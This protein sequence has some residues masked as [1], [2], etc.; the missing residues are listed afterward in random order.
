MPKM[1]L[2]SSRRLAH[3]RGRRGVAGTSFRPCLVAAGI[4]LSMSAMAANAD[5]SVAEAEDRSG[6]SKVTELDGLKVT[7]RRVVENKSG[8][9]LGNRSELDT[10][11]SV[12]TVTGEDIEERQASTLAAVFAKD[13]SVSDA[14]SE[15]SGFPSSAQIRGLASD[16]YNS[17]KLNG[18]PAG[19]L[20]GINL[21]T[22]FME[23]VQLLK[24]S[25]GFMYGFSA[26]GGIINYVTKKPTE[27]RLASFDAGYKSGNIYGQHL[28]LG[29]RLFGEERFGYRFNVSN[30]KGTAANG[31]RIDRQ[32][33]ALSLEAKLAP[34]LTWTID[35]MAQQ[36]DIDRPQ[37]E[38]Y[39][40]T[41]YTSTTLP[42]ALDGSE[43]L[44]TDES[45]VHNKFYY[46]GTSLNW[47]ISPDWSLR[48]DLSK[49]YSRLLAYSEFTYLLN[50]AGDL[51]YSTWTGLD[52]STTQFGQAMLQGT[53][54]TGPITHELVLGVSHE[55]D[56]MDL[57]QINFTQSSRVTTYSN[58][59]SP[60][61]VVWS[62]DTDQTTYFYTST[63]QTAAFLSDTMTLAE[64]WSLLA[65]L[66]YTRYERTAYS[67]YTQN[68]SGGLDFT[69]R[70]YRKYPL[71][72]T[73]ALLYKPVADATIYASYVESMER[74][75]TVGSSYANYGEVLDP[76]LSKQYEL[77]FK[78]VRPG[79]SA[80]AALFRIERG[81]EYADA[82]NY[83]VQDGEI[84]YDGAELAGD[85][86]VTRNLKLGASALYLDSS[87][88]NTSD[89]WLLG[90]AQKG[91]RRFTGA[92]SANYDVERVPGLS[93]HA[94]GKYYG[95]G[96]AYNNTALDLV[97]K[98]PAYALF[99]LGA[100]YRT[101]L[102]GYGV[103]VR[104]EV[105]NLFDRAYWALAGSYVFPGMPRVLALNV[106]IDM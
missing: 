96:I 47:E 62:P 34:D 10:P 66:R 73:L 65:G 53:F 24:G 32:A 97:V 56:D 101:R 92:L 19:F 59:Y 5:D 35:A 64:K 71:T 104:G 84:R 48:V 50:Q 90:K 87:Y 14:G 70:T 42:A 39:L 89:E 38:Y 43:N 94:D 26:P 102:G 6:K 17:L 72:P 20:Y 99:N 23:Q 2:P 51:Q 8:G 27:E 16:Y 57:G 103:T 13:A 95:E 1:I 28:D 55:D 82:D 77:G 29:G 54:R 52:I 4:A 15:Y 60:T 85:V 21:P 69:Y 63:A 67:S 74:G 58:L 3:A 86:R 83:Y 31:S 33:A 98:S 106:K 46:L 75:S 80:S 68:A 44:T 30:E 100:A 93:L 105:Q 25:S 36:R 22:E 37:T 61:P 40:S 11:F 9:A 78:W 81:A 12:V 18:L 7:G 79:W 91:S 76:L 49:M 88:R 45:I 41:S